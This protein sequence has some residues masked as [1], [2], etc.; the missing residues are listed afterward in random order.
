MLARLDAGKLEVARAP[1]DL[2]ST[3]FETVDLFRARAIAEEI[4]LDLRVSGKL[5]ARGDAKGTV[6]VLG[7]LLDNA[8]RF[9]PKGGRVSV[10]GAVRD[11]HAEATVADT[12]P[13][14]PAEH[15]S[16][17]FDRFYRAEAARARKGGGTGLGLAIARDLARA[18]GGELTAENASESGAIFRLT[19]PGG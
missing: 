3:L 4:D 7:V 6:Q 8:L 9:T 12:G 18:Q 5:P 17:V 16:R 13:G 11:G 10:S 2:A 15:L 14:I 1:F 19:L